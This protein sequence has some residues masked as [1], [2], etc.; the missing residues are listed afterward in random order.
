[1][2]AL[3][4]HRGS[5]GRAPGGVASGR[6]DPKVT[7]SDSALGGLLKWIGCQPGGHNVFI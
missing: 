6:R 4:C 1:M 3:S 2:A 7:L 5:A